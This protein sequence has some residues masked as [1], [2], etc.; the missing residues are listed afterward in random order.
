MTTAYNACDV[1]VS[2][3]N[4]DSEFSGGDDANGGDHHDL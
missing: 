3:G 4:D 1:I 2:S